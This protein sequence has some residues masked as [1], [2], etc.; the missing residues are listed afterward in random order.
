MGQSG[1]ELE[2]SGFLQPSQPNI[3]GAANPQVIQSSHL[4]ILRTQNTPIKISVNL[5]RVPP[6]NGGNLQVP[7][8]NLFGST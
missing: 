8:N 1:S 2:V 6:K 5:N 4:G 7:G 3:L